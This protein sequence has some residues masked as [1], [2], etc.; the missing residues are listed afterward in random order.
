MKESVNMISCGTTG[1][2][3]WQVSWKTHFQFTIETGYLQ[4]SVAFIEWAISSEAVNNF[5]GRLVKF[6]FFF[7]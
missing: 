6:I 4:A 7:V 3:T 2:I 5:T 1:L